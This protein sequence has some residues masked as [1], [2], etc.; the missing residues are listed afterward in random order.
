MCVRASVCVWDGWREGWETGMKRRRGGQRAGG[1]R[2]RREVQSEEIQIKVTENGNK[3]KKARKVKNNLKI[4]IVCSTS[5]TFNIFFC[6]DFV[7]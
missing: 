5:L 6:F 3:K 2:R 7:K 4:K 1:M